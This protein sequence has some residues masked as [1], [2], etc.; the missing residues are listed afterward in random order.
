MLDH[1][2]QISILATVARGPVYVIIVISYFLAYNATDVM[3]SDY[4]ATVLSAK[5]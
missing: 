4:F 2:G 3:D 1:E 5:M